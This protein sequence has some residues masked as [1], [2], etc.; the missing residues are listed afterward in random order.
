MTPHLFMAGL[1]N[2]IRGR[3]V[4]GPEPEEGRQSGSAQGKAER[5]TLCQEGKTAQTPVSQFICPRKR[6]NTNTR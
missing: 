2:D 3:D 1:K 4:F 5:R 6:T